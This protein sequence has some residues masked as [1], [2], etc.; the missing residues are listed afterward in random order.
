MVEVV[1]GSERSLEY[2][3]TWAVVLIISCF[4]VISLVFERILHWL[5]QVSCAL[6]LFVLSV[7]VGFLV[8]NSATNM[9]MNIRDHYPKL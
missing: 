5:G 3:S 8:F 1:P 2:T 6:L 9:M 7:G 4:V